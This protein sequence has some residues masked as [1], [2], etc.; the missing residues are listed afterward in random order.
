MIDK[1]KAALRDALNWLNAWGSILLAYALANPSAFAELRNLLP[2]AIQP[3]APL[4]ALGWF[5]VVQYAKAR[6][7]KAKVEAENKPAS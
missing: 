4:A 5:F 2:A 3:Y 7:L 6:A 1:L